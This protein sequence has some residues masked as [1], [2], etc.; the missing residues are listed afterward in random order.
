MKPEYVQRTFA[1]LQVVALLSGTAAMAQVGHDVPACLERYGRPMAGQI[2]TNGYGTLHFATKDLGI[3]IEFVSG[4]AQRVLYQAACLDT[5]TVNRLLEQNADS[6]N[7]APWVPPGLGQSED[8]SRKWIRSDEEA[9]AELTD[10]GL[11]IVGS[12][13]YRHLA[14]SPL[15]ASTTVLPSEGKI[16]SAAAMRSPVEKDNFVGL[17]RSDSPGSATVVLQARSEGHGRWIVMGAHYRHE[18]EVGWLRHAAEGE[19]TYVVHDKAGN[20]HDG[21]P[22]TIGTFRVVSDAEMHFHPNTAVMGSQAHFHGWGIAPEMKF[23]R[24]ASM[25]RWKPAAPGV[26]PSKGDSRK[27]AIRI[28]GKPTGTMRS[29]GSEVLVYPW[30]NVWIVNGVVTGID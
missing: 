8:E 9:M 13:W 11:T 6:A 28:L 22:V 29:G 19:T 23:H 5:Q 7:W 16:V 1:V 21:D 20:T 18:K 4:R 25:P 26:L 2:G 17:W 10:A 24:I 15:P 27:D 12:G 30:G 14:S 3:E